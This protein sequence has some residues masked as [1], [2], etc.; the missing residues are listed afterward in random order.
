MKLSPYKAL[1]LLLSLPVTLQAYFRSETGRDY[2]LGIGQKLRLMAKLI[3][4]NVSITSGSN[5]VEHLV[6]VTTVLCVPREREGSLV[7]CGSYKGASTAA[8][9]LA[10]SIT[11]RKLHVFDSFAGLPEPS[12]SD[13]EHQVVHWGE[14]H[15]YEAGTWKG[16]LQ[17]VRGNIAKYGSLES[18][19]FHVGFFDA[20]LPSFDEPT[21]FVFADVDLRDSLEVC[22]EN[23]WG[24]LADGGSF[25]TH[26]APHMEIARLFFTP[27][28][29][30]ERFATEPPGLIG[31]G[32]GLGLIPRASGFGSA[33]GYTIKDAES[34]RLEHRPQ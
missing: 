6:M 28:W 5:F 11:G 8:L 30:H 3:R 18:C 16:T 23:L 4:N 9:S 12:S 20:T 25:Y 10:A 13:R 7:E 2:G 1:L 31:A 22:V 34:L 26:E 33:L 29:W 17:E 27:D 15:T 21:V 19:E 24:N 14:L 32:T